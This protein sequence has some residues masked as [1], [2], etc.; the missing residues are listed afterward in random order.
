[1]QNSMGSWLAEAARCVSEI[2]RGRDV[3]WEGLVEEC[4][5]IGVSNGGLP[6]CADASCDLANPSHI[7]V[8]DSWR[9]YAVWTQQ[10]AIGHVSGWW[11]LV[12][13]LP[14]TSLPVPH[15]LPHFIL[16]VPFLWQF[17][18]VG[19]AIE[20]S[21]SV[22]ISWDGREVSHCTS[23]ATSKQV[24]DDALLS[25]FFS[26]PTNVVNAA[27]RK[28]EMKAALQARVLSTPGSTPELQVGQHVWAK[29][30][31]DRATVDGWYR[32]TA[33][34]SKISPAGVTVSWTGRKGT[35]TA[36][37]WHQAHNMLVRAGRLA[38]FGAGKSQPI[39]EELVGRKIS[40]YWPGDDRMYGG[41]VASF[42]V[43]LGT[44]RII[45][46]DGDDLWELLGS[47]DAPEYVVA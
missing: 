9:S 36:L 21:D 34:V 12:R 16:Y 42:D 47:V 28:Q 14:L 29:W 38:P 6:S 5:R 33:M 32:A 11:F 39:G 23:V 2:F 10:R 13:Q 8:G 30:W 4:A 35:H 1:M 43:A 41:S 20:L 19:L 44:H 22:A 31:V 17:P 24:P 15:S 37:T 45:Y 25:I 26:L 7:D 27:E 3:G 46:N 18:D 40:V